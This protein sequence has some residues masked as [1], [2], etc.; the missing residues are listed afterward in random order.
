MKIIKGKKVIIRMTMTKII[1]N[2]PLSLVQNDLFILES[3]KAIVIKVDK[4]NAF[5]MKLAEFETEIWFT[6]YLQRNNGYFFLVC[7][8][9]STLLCCAAQ[10]CA[11]LTVIIKQDLETRITQRE[12][13]EY[14]DHAVSY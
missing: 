12:F 8:R 1:V 3:C 11:N 6:D 4:W 14:W 13:F 7:V 10:Q 5:R 2:W 9:V